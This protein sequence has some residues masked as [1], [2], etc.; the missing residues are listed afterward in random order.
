VEDKE[1]VVEVVAVNKRLITKLKPLQENRP[2]LE[3]SLTKRWV[4]EEEEDQIAKNLAKRSLK[5]FSK[6]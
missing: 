4:A 1:E 2:P 3:K 5:P 6:I